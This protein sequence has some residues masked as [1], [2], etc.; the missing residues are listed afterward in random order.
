MPNYLYRIQQQTSL[1]FGD[2][3]GFS[4]SALDISLKGLGLA[5]YIDDDC[6]YL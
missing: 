3:L 5:R 2:Q 4:V 6:A 1:P